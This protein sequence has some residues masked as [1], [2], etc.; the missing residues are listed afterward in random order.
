MA[1][2]QL[3]VI[4]SL[5]ADDTRAEILTLLM[6]GRA[7]TGSELARHTGVAPSTASE[8]LSK[9][10]DAGMIAV[11]AQGRHRYFRLA[12][13][14]VADILE[15]L[16]ATPALTS[17]PRPRAPA[18]LAYARTC[19]DHLAGELA[20]HVYD[21][22]VAQGHLHETDDRLVLTSSGLE[23]LDSIGVDTEALRSG[24]RP[25]AR[26]CLDWT[27]RRHHL[28]GAAGAGLLDALLAN[29]WVAH[30][31][32]PRSLRVTSTGNK[33]ITEIFAIADPAQPSR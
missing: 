26:R 22:L 11:E 18:A 4:G 10:L 30:D 27:E 31:R 23:L 3:S 29:R 25:K 13:I 33:A 17:A 8:H 9:L 16:G 24:K 19:Y 14:E 2:S 6:D 5:L 7:H 21:Q 20:V 28:A 12:S 32:Q 15:T 1:R